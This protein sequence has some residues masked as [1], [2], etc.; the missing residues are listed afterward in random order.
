MRQTEM[1][2]IETASM[3]VFHTLTGAK[4]GPVR[5]LLPLVDQQRPAT[6]QA[7]AVVG[8]ATSSMS[9]TGLDHP[10]GR[11]GAAS[12]P[13]LLVPMLMLLMLLM[14]AIAA[15]AVS[16]AAAST[17]AAGRRL[18]PWV[19]R[20]RGGANIEAGSDGEGPAGVLRK[21]EFELVE[22]GDR[23]RGRWRSILKVCLSLCAI[24]IRVVWD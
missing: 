1:H 13:R 17:S 7:T 19:L 21:E 16:A 15:S 2:P 11:R 3:R 14:L 9:T 22:E 23:Y 10:R 20:T 5:V 8:Y 4:Q 6:H 12:T 18:P 24:E